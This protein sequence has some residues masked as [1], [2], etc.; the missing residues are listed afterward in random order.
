VA[1]LGHLCGILLLLTPP[2][3]GL[4]MLLFPIWVI[5]LSLMVLF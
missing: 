1:L 2:L 3:P 5:T 4:A